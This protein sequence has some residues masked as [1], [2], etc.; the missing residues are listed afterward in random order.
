MFRFVKEPCKVL[1]VNDG[2]LGDFVHSIPFINA[3]QSGC[4]DVTV[5]TKENYKCRLGYNIVSDYSVIND[6]S[7]K[8]IFLMNEKPHKYS[9]F[10]KNVF[11]FNARR[12]MLKARGMWKEKHWVDFYLFWAEDFLKKKIKMENFLKSTGEDVVFHPGSSN[13]EKNWD[14]ENFIKVYNATLSD[15][16]YF[17]IGPDDKYLIPKLEENNCVYIESDSINTL[18]HIASKTALF[19]G[20]DSGVSH[21]F[22]LF[23]IKIVSI[24]SIGCGLT[25]F[26]Y[27]KNAMF[28]F[29]SD[30]FNKYMKTK[31]ITKI[32]LSS[33]EVISSI[34]FY[35]QNKKIS[36]PNFYKSKDKAQHL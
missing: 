32:E 28:Y 5:L 10:F 25:H 23:D 18:L 3:L 16:K 21:I 1:I 30:V 24:F 22:S 35:L 2:A 31:E 15:N 6:K 20:S 11:D 7:F 34:N 26:P 19:V 27:N 14:I 9:Y 36:F 4:Y 12:S 13:S 17:I 8:M 33:K 29:N